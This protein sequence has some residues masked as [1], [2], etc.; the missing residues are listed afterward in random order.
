MD[1]QEVLKPPHQPSERDKTS[2]RLLQWTLMLVTTILIVQHSWRPNQVVH[3]QTALLKSSGGIQICK[4]SLTSWRRI[5][6]LM[7]RKELA[8]LLSRHLCSLSTTRPCTTC[9]SNQSRT[10]MYKESGSSES[11]TTTSFAHYTCGKSLSNSRCGYNGF[12]QDCEWKQSCAGF[13]RPARWPFVCP[14]PDQRWSESHRFYWKR[15][16]HFLESPEVLLSD[17]GTN[18]LSHLTTNICDLQGIRKLT[19]Q[20]TIP[21]VMGW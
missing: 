14:N 20:P 4:K 7:T 15:W 18:I 13:G 1:S 17:Q 16:S 8:R 2:P 6:S 11:A 9:T 3:C 21:N 5:N 12:A 10:Y 19:Q